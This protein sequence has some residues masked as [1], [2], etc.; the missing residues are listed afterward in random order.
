GAD[1]SGGIGTGGASGTSGGATAGGGVGTAG[2]GAGAGVSAGVGTGG[3]SGT[4]GGATA[5]VGGGT[6]GTGA[7]VGGSVGVGGVGPGTRGIGGGGGTTGGGAARGS[8]TG[9]GGDGGKRNR[10]GGPA[11][12]RN[13]RRRQGRRGRCG[14]RHG[15]SGGRWCGGRGDL[16]RGGLHHKEVPGQRAVQRQRR[17]ELA[18]PDTDRVAALSLGQQ[19]RGQGAAVRPARDLRRVQAHGLAVPAARGLGA[20]RRATAPDRRPADGVPRQRLPQPGRLPDGSRGRGHAAQRLLEIGR[21]IKGCA[22]EPLAPLA[23]LAALE[24]P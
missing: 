4:G 6:A 1:G 13:G 5:G 12:R 18:H 14:R 17:G 22:R 3:T 10:S 20:A 7:G 2:T 11:A 15:W 8:G 16:G 21:S 19:A 24:S 9:G 23:Q